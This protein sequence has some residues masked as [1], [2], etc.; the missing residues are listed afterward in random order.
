MNNF[1]HLSSSQRTSTYTNIANVSLGDKLFGSIYPKYA[2][3]N[4][5]R[6]SGISRKGEAFGSMRCAH[7]LCYTNPAA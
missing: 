5:C 1:G 2:S 6:R 7:S 3:Q 4:V